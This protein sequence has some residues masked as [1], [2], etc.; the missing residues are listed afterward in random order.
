MKRVL[1]LLG[2]CACLIADDLSFNGEFR[3]R[4]EYYN[5]VNAKYYGQNPSIGSSNDAYLL[6][7]LRL[8]ATYKADDSLLFKVGMQDSRTLGYGLSDDKWYSREFLQ[9]NNPQKDYFEFYETYVQKK[10]SRFEIKVGRQKMTYG[11]KR[12]FGP[13]EWKNSGKWVWDAIKAVYRVDKDFVS[14]FYGATMLHDE[15]KL[16]IAHRH[17]YYGYGMYSHFE[18]GDF[19]IEPMLF[20]KENTKNNEL[21]NSLRGY[22]AGARAYGNAGKFFYDSTF[23]KAFGKREDLSGYDATI[24]AYAFVGVLGYNIDQSLNIGAEYVFA[25]GDNPS[26]AKKEG[27]DTAFGAG[28]LYY[29]RMNLMQISNLIDYCAFSNIKVTPLLKAKL[30]YHRF[31]AD[32]PT[33]KW[34]SYQIDTMQSDHYGDEIDL[35][36]KYVKDKNLSFQL[37]LGYFFD[38]SYIKE[39]SQTNSNITSTDAY[40]VFTQVTFSF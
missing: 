29:G 17:G 35:V 16:S 1:L 11:D 14:F 19:K 18:F 20:A 3:A 8:G 37:G 22:Y 23:I 6:S 24:D 12:I 4:H 38:G 26:T 25:S 7:R 5:G 30:E 34:L 2:I 9:K 40:S 28:D 32:R 10:V 31:Y 13:G 33:N 39:A 15:D 36:A 21:Y 27:Y